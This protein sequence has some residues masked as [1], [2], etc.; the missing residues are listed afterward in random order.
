MATRVYINFV[1]GADVPASV[2]EVRRIE[3]VRDKYLLI[4]HSAG[5]ARAFRFIDTPE[6]QGSV[7]SPNGYRDIVYRYRVEGSTV[8]LWVCCVVPAN[9]ALPT[10]D[11]EVITYSQKETLFLAVG[12]TDTTDPFS[13]PVDWVPRALTTQQKK[14]RAIGKIKAFREQKKTWLL[15]APEYADLV[16]DIVTHLGYWLRSADYVIKLMYD[17]GVAGTLDWLIVAKIAEE[18]MKGP[19][20]L[21]PDGDGAYN[22]EFFQRLKV[23]ATNFPTGPSFGALWVRTWDLSDVGDVDRVSD[24]TANVISSHG[25]TDPSLP[26]RTYHNIPATYN[27]TAEYWTS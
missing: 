11:Y 9:T 7:E 15:E 25:S 21:D 5:Q 13:T 3:I 2:P 19:R 1:R 22:V 8:H 26:D 10:P 23:A 14:E 17:L 12:Q 24:F 6:T 27:S 18:A 16:P 20:T 4:R